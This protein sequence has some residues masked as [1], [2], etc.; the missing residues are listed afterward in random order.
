MLNVNVTLEMQKETRVGS[1][2]VD[3]ALNLWCTVK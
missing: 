3:L 1:F 2:D